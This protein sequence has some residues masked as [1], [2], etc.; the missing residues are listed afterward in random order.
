MRNGSKILVCREIMDAKA[1]RIAAHSPSSTN[2]FMCY[3]YGSNN[4]INSAV[5]IHQL[6]L[7][8]PKPAKPLKTSRSWRETTKSIPTNT[9]CANILHLMDSLCLPITTDMYTCLIKECTFQKDSPGALELL[10]HI[11]K[12]TNIK[13]TLLFLNRLLVMLV[14]CGQL[15]TARQLFDE[16][17]LRDFNS[18]AVMIVGYIDVADYQECITLFAEMMKHKKGHMLLEFPAWIIVCALKACVCTM[19]MELGKQVHGLLFKLGS[20]RNISLSGSL[21]NFYGKFRCLDDADFV[22]SQLKFHNTVVWT[23]KIVNNCREGH[24]HQVFNDFKEMARKRIKKNSYTFSSVLKACGGVDDDG[25]CGRQVHANIVKIGLESDEY[26]QCG[27]VDMYGKCRLLRDAERVFELIVDNKNIAS[28]NAMLMGYIRNGLYVEATK[29]LY[30]MKAS[31]IQIQESLIKDVRIACS[32]GSNT[33]QNRMEQ[34]GTVF[35]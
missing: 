23:A 14:S 1:L 11:R 29:F 33:L 8:S 27:L 19:N 7:R 9:S 24:F 31:G 20:S 22:F 5:E 15:D 35:P 16:M 12:R 21:I 28:W 6:L 13:P 26:V 2:R 3:P 34:T 25:N 17:P 30:L 10:Y 32:N 4:H 18:W